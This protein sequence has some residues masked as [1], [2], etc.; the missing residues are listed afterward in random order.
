MWTRVPAD[1]GGG[2]TLPGDGKPLW[3][4]S[5]RE[6]LHRLRPDLTSVWNVSPRKDQVSRDINARAKYANVVGADTMISLHSNAMMK[7]HHGEASG[8]RVYVLANR[9]E[10]YRL[11][12]ALLCGMREMIHDQDAY[13]DWKVGAKPQIADRGENKTRAAAAI[14]EVGFHDNRQ[15]VAALKDPAFL[16]AAML[17]VTKGYRLWRQGLACE[18]NPGIVVPEVTAAEENVPLSVT[19]KGEPTWPGRLKV[20]SVGSCPGGWQCQVSQEFTTWS[21]TSEVWVACQREPDLPAAPPPA[22]V[23]LKVTFTDDYDVERTAQSV[24]HC[25]PRPDGG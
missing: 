12:E 18:K 21:T 3:T 22:D 20:E 24:M 11:G 17:G 1:L 14:V 16:D 25:V 13:S 23:P 19:V 6:Q 7:G 2:V 15:D 10:S 4:L 8:T 9:P 5:A